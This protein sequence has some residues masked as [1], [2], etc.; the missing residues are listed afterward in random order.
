MLYLGT[1]QKLARYILSVVSGFDF[2]E[3]KR[4]K[5][6]QQQQDPAKK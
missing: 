5:E 4:K 6:Q 2:K 1:F 3:K